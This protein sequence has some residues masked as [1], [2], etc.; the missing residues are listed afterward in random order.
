MENMLM[1]T[2]TPTQGNTMADI[3]LTAADIAKILQVSP[4]VVAEKY[5]M[6]PNFPV[7][8]RLPSPK[9]QGVHRWK[10]EEIMTWIDSLREGRS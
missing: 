7:P 10:R 4:R 8:L 9:G 6:H 2:N 5:A 1:E 3:L